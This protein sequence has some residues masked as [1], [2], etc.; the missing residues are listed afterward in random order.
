MTLD[1]APSP[2]EGEQCQSPYTENIDTRLLLRGC[3][4]PAW[5]VNLGRQLILWG[6]EF[7]A[8]PLT[9]LLVLQ[10]SCRGPTA[11]KRRAGLWAPSRRGSPPR[12]CF[13]VKTVTRMAASDARRQTSPTCSREVLPTPTPAPVLAS[14]LL[15]GVSLLSPEMLLILPKEVIITSEASWNCF[16]NVWLEYSPSF[17][18]VQVAILWK[19]DEDNQ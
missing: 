2:P 16:P 15:I 3:E 17:H 4:D 13:P 11:W 6:R 18:T 14:R 12:T 1:T 5:T 9:Q 10:A 8:P 19:L 7:A